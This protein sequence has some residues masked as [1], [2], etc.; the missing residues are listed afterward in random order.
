MF[1]EGAVAVVTGIGPGMGRSI[2]LGYA[3][4]GVDV[5][6]AARRKERLDAVADEVRKLGREPL[7][8]PTDLTDREACSALIDAAI[9]RFGGI[10]ILVQNGHHEGDWTTVADADP[11]SWRNIFE[12]NFFSAL[13]L[14]HRVIPAMRERGGG[15]IVFVNSGGALS[16]PPTMGAYATSKA[17]LATLTRTLAKEVGRWNIRVNGV[18][19]GPV[20]GE[21]LERLGAGAAKASGT[22]LDQWLEVKATEMPLGFVPT[23][24]QCAGSVHFLTSDL[25][26]AVTGQHLSV[27]GGQ[28]T[29]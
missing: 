1:R 13:H 23:P 9:E 20:A 19:L 6:L 18:Y 14:T 16:V 25:A 27:N 4:R 10:D 15:S 17:A 29:T 2:A 26:A 8:V 12:V 7:V 5:V 11:D 28:W 3:E 22:T 24:D 21:N